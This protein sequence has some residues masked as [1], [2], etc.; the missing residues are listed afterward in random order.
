MADKVDSNPRY[1]FTHTRVP[2]VRLKP[3]GHLSLRYSVSLQTQSVGTAAIYTDEFAG[4]NLYLRQNE[5]IMTFPQKLAGFQF[6][7]AL[8]RFFSR[9]YGMKISTFSV[10]AFDAGVPK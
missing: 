4:I 1:A 9:E 5:E 8:I 10:A 7:A 2:G 6:G 3:L